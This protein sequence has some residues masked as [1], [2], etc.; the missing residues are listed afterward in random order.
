[1]VNYKK[2]CFRP[3]S[4]QFLKGRQF[5]GRRFSGP[6]NQWLHPR[7][8]VP[9]PGPFRRSFTNRYTNSI[10]AFCCGFR[11]RPRPCPTP[12]SM[13]HPGNL[14]R[15]CSLFLLFKA[16]VSPPHPPIRHLSLIIYCS[17]LGRP[18]AG[19]SGRQSVSCV[20]QIIWII[21]ANLFDCPYCQ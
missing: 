9:P 4:S 2:V 7:F 1:M 21:L 19:D 17:A 5:L 3:G 6:P 16:G 10:R 14:G 13:S 11:F 8:F 20:P 12:R 18:L 15:R